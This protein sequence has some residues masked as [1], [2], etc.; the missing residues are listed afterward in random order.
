MATFWIDMHFCMHFIF[1]AGHI[2]ADSVFYGNCMIIASM[3]K[4]STSFSAIW[5][6]NTHLK[7]TLLDK[8]PPKL[9]PN[10]TGWLVYGDTGSFPDPQI[11]QKF[12]DYDDFDLVPYDKIDRL[13]PDHSIELTVEMIT[14]K[15]GAN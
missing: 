10:A 2:K 6:E 14:L 4:V 5:E 12:D 15:D 13:E 3:D 11:I 1:L 9:N 8:I 7:Q